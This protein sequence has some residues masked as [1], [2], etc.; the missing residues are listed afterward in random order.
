MNTQAN[1][2]S[3]WMSES[4]AAAI[5]MVAEYL[6]TQALPEAD[7]GEAT[8]TLPRHKAADLVR[9][10]IETGRRIGI[11]EMVRTDQQPAEAPNVSDELF[12]I[13]GRL[14][15]LINRVE[16]AVILADF[17]FDFV[18]G[19]LRDR[20]YNEEEH[21]KASVA[22]CE[23]SDHIL[24]VVRQGIRDAVSAITRVNTKLREA[25]S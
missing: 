12:E 17:A 20:D 3:Y 9:E 4:T 13:S 15:G 6:V 14:T 8:C 22:L 5:K 24:P 18:G 21:H 25:D 2:P 10:A 19:N 23:Q 7:H 11:A 16:A 1:E